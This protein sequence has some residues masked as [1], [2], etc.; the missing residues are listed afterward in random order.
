M[1]YM[2]IFDLVAMTLTFTVLVRPMIHALQRNNYR[3]I[4]LWNIL[5]S[6]YYSVLILMQVVMF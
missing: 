5:F 6:R 4:A 2:Q 3:P 1:D